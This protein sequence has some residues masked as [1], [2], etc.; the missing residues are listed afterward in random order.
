MKRVVLLSVFLLFQSICVQS[1]HAKSIPSHPIDE[2]VSYTLEGDTTHFEFLQYDGTELVR[3]GQVDRIIKPIGWLA[4]DIDETLSLV[5]YLPL[6]TTLKPDEGGTLNFSIEAEQ[7]D[8]ASPSYSWKLDDTKVSTSKEWTYTPDYKSPGLHTVVGLATDGKLSVSKEWEVEV[9]KFNRAPSVSLLSPKSGDALAKDANI[10]WKATDPNGDELDIDISYSNDA[11]NTWNPLASGKE[12]DGI[13]T[14]DT[15][16]VNDGEYILKIVA[17]DPH[18]LSAENL[19]GSIFIENT[20]PKVGFIS[21]DAGEIEGIQKIVWQVSDT[22]GAI[23]VV[24]SMSSDDGKTWESL[25]AGEGNHGSFSWDT[26]KVPDGTYI[27]RVTAENKAGKGEQTLEVTVDNPEYG[28]LYISSIPRGASIIIGGKDFGK[29]DSEVE[30]PA[31][32]HTIK[33][34]KEGYSSW[35]EWIEV[36]KGK[37]PDINVRLIPSIYGLSP[38]HI[39]A[40]GLAVLLLFAVVLFYVKGK[41]K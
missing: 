34:Q 1:I 41:K 37:N 22:P 13:F 27:L 16:D 10:T 17:S 38:V 5:S 20:L 3:E 31:G 35:A 30:I 8:G 19:S 40:L 36:K 24:L 12:N 7:A 9:G 26:M 6:D 39:F 23:S 25:A 21:P 32:Y 11:G 14:W 2:I 4:G 18:G 15:G 28:F 33:I 29:T